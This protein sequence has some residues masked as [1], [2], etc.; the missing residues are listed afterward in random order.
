MT[1][2]LVLALFVTFLVVERF[3]NKKAPEF[4]LQTAPRAEAGARKLS[5]SSPALRFR[6][7]SASTK[8]MPGR[9]ARARTWCA[10]G[11][12]TLPPS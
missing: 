1:V 3:T 11:S 2:I 6:N 10:P 12:T 4:V 8:V 7:T 5:P 9:W